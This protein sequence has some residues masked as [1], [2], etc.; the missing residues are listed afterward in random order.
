MLVKDIGRR[1][2]RRF[3]DSSGAQIEDADIYD[4]INDAQDDINRKIEFLTATS[5]LD[6]VDGTENYALPADF[7][8]ALRVTLDGTFLYKTTLEEMDQYLRDRDVTP[9][10]KGTP[11]R[12][13][14][15]GGRIFLY[16]IPDSASAGT[17][18][19]DVFY[20]KR[21]T[22]IATTA[23]ISADST[24]L[25]LPAQMHESI[26]DYCLWKAKELNEDV[27]QAD[28]FKQSY[29]SKVED[30]MMESHNPNSNSYPAVRAL[31]GDD[32][33]EWYGS[34]Y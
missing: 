18:L 24:A 21:P 26:V 8:Y 13:W 4:W 20:V 2:K 9:V 27:T 15:R 30:S 31:P 32:G 22:T 7:V 28:R 19:L 14:I 16:P 1:V 12:Y 5:Q 23:D 3:G 11:T 25:D 6:P 34:G 29:E 17:D 10:Q 33:S